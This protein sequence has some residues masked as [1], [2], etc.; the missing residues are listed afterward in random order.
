MKNILL[1]VLA[2]SLPAFSAD[3]NFTPKADISLSGKIATVKN[4][5]KYRSIEACQ[6]FCS[7]RTSCAAFTLD[8]EKGSCTLLKSITKETVNTKAVS[9]IKN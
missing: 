6:A 7:T 9:G 2:T 8:T 4:S 5:K 1:I 3:M